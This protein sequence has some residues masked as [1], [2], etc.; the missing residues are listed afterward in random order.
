ALWNGPRA[1]GLTLETFRTAVSGL[2]RQTVDFLG[3]DATAYLKKAESVATRVLT[4]AVLA[5]SRDL[6]LGL[7][8][9]CHELVK[10]MAGGDAVS[11]V[12]IQDMQRHR[13]ATARAGEIA[14]LEQM[15]RLSRY[16]AA[17]P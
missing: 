14:V 5:R 9:L 6:P 1:L 11:H 17:P 3:A 7:D 8:N 2:A 15:A 16:L 10:E 13:Y 4:P 12:A